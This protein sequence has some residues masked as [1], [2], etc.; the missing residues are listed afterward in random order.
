MLGRHSLIEDALFSQLDQ[1]NERGFESLAAALS[2][3]DSAAA[4]LLRQRQAYRFVRLKLLAPDTLKNFAA[5]ERY[6][7]SMLSWL[8]GQAVLL[9][10]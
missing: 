3:D 8:D 4:A 5:L 9:D 2:A 1:D 10:V 7:Q 6:I